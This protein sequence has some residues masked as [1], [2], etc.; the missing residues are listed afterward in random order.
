MSP[1]LTELRATLL[2]EIAR[3]EEQVELIREQDDLGAAINL[4]AREIAY[5]RVVRLIETGIPLS[6]AAEA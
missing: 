5:R 4:G 1:E 2:M 6:A 3:I